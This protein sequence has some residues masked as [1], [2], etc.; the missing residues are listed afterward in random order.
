MEYT[1]FG[2]TELQVSKIAFGTWHL[3]FGELEEIDIIMRGAVP[4]GGPTPEG[5]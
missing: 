5:M 3:T 2:Q 4:V 1:Q